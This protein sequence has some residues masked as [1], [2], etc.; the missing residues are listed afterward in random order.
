MHACDEADVDAARGDQYLP[1]FR[2]LLH[3]S[4]FAGRYTGAS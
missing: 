4:S 3:D 1:K 2:L